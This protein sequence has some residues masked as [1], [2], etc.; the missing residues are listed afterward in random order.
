LLIA[1]RLR[2]LVPLPAAVPPAMAA[3]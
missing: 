3:A 1:L 2:T